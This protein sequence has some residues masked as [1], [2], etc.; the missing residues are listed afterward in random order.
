MPSS[1]FNKREEERV[2]NVLKRDLTPEQR[3][4]Y[5]RELA[6]IQASQGKNP[7]TKLTDT[8]KEQASL[9]QMPPKPVKTTVT[10]TEPITT[11]V[12]TSPAITSSET[13]SVKDSSQAQKF[14]AMIMTSKYESQKFQ[15]AETRS[16]QKIES[17]PKEGSNSTAN[18]I[19]SMFIPEV[20]KKKI[21]TGGK[22]RADFERNVDQS[23]KKQSIPKYTY[24]DYIEKF[25]SK[26]SKISKFEETAAYSA[27]SFDVGLAI[28]LASPYIPAV[29]SKPLQ[30]AGYGFIGKDVYESAKKGD[31]LWKIP[32][33]AA[34]FAGGYI[35][36]S[37]SKLAISEKQNIN[38][39]KE[40]TYDIR[41]EEK[42]FTGQV[43]KSGIRKGEVTKKLMLTESDSVDDVAGKFL[44]LKYQKESTVVSGKFGIYKQQ[45]GKA[46]L[47]YISS[48][49]DVFFP[50][51]AEIFDISDKQFSYI[52]YSKNVLAYDYGKIPVTEVRINQMG[53]AYGKVNTNVKPGLYEKIV[54]ETPRVSSD[55]LKPYEFFEA[56]K[57]VSATKPFT[58]AAISALPQQSPQISNYLRGITTEV[59]GGFSKLDN[60]EY[61]GKSP[62]SG[63]SGKVWNPERL[64]PSSAIDFETQITKEISNQS[65]TKEMNLSVESSGQISL[66]SQSSLQD[67]S[68]RFVESLLKSTQTST[69]KE[70]Q[71]Q[72]R[73]EN[74]VDEE[75]IQRNINLITGDQTQKMNQ[76]L[77]IFPIFDPQK[78]IDINTPQKIYER[79]DIGIIYPPTD[80]GFIKKKKKKQQNIMKGFDVEVRKAGKWIKATS[81]P[82]QETEALKLGA[83]ITETTPR[84]SFRLTESVGTPSV[85]KVNYNFA[86]ERFRQPISRGMQSSGKIFIEKS[87]Y[88]INTPGELKG[89]TFAPRK[90]GRGIF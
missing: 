39:I 20:E 80:F 89:I 26:P 7:S 40:G 5:E 45:M 75:Q 81:M 16:T 56:P 59:Y 74:I 15:Q 31:I 57:V 60:D 30:V 14:N 76:D 28:G 34:G 64:V 33:Y 88:R 86:P 66:Q 46:R 18:K 67:Q 32:Q 68:K 65:K 1:D 13:I 43:D 82:L 87:K 61:S 90:K 23:L 37:Y 50:D 12:T 47:G 71:S 49:K 35:G 62:M 52:D 83:K 36:S 44:D 69:R 85:M 63:M 73:I 41:F 9:E 54:M 17:L 21:Y 79:E 22:A 53:G 6:T 19:A 4:S 55:Q 77:I 48:E 29:V 42:R 10:T 72:I 58:G 70:G 2:K 27:I 3:R 51:K 11:T 38:K 24:P 25:E 84:A 8:R 78:P